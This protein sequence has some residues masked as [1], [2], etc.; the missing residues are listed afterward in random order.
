MLFIIKKIIFR[1]RFKDFANQVTRLQYLLNKCKREI[2]NYVK[3]HYAEATLLDN[4]NSFKT[5]FMSDPNYTICEIIND[6]LVL[7]D[8]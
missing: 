5:D 2:T 6:E 4:I 8:F 7:K 1:A 3:N